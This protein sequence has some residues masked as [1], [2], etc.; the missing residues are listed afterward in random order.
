MDFLLA[1]IELFFAIGLRTDRRD[2]EYRLKIAVFAATGQ[3]APK[4]SGRRGR[5]LP[6]ILRVRKLDEF[7]FRVV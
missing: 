6:T 3:F 1:I 4:I 2:S 7:P 5:S